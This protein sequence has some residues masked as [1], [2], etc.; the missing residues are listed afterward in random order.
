MTAAEMVSSRM[1]DGM[2]PALALY[3]TAREYGTTVSAIQ[4]RRAQLRR[5]RTA[6]RRRPS[7][8][9]CCECGTAPAERNG[10]CRRCDMC[11]ASTEA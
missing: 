2:S 9:M 11:V 3:V 10:R 7:V 5:E 1:R 6:A 8:P 4:R